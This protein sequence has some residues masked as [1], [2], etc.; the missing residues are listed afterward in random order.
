MQGD[1]FQTGRL[2]LPETPPDP[3]V[4]AE[5]IPFAA[6]ILV[7]VSILLF[8]L[9]LRSFLNVLPYL[10]DSMLRAR[11]SAALENSV[12]VSRDRN[13]V[14]A[15]FLIPVVLLVYRYRLYD[16]AFLQDLDPNS[17]LLVVA[18]VFGGYLL[19]RFL[20]YLWARPRRRYD[21]YQMAYRAGY[22]FFILL[23]MLSLVTVGILWVLHCSDLTVKTFLLVE[24][25]VIYFLYLIRRGQ[26][27]STSCKPLTTFLYLCGLELLPTAALVLTAV[28]L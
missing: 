25:G 8:L 28:I 3:A 14:A 13:V 5:G 24:A 18:G 22:T 27:L 17:R 10:S 16:P 23:S 7:S 1:P 26:I 4:A 9:T 2:L 19:L 21:D 15:V 12:K 11:G 6:V 20:L